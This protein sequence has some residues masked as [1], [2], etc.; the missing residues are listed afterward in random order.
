MGAFEASLDHLKN[1]VEYPADAEQVIQACN[2]MSD[3]PGTDK[4]WFANTLPAGT[5]NDPNEVVSA[6]LEKL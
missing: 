1:H 3:V 2:N 5:Y 4:E 6:V